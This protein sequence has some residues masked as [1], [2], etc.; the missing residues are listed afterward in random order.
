M[1]PTNEAQVKAINDADAC[2]NNV[3]LPNYSDLMKQVMAQNE[4]LAKSVVLVEVKNVYGNETIYPAN[5]A[6]RIF[7]AIAGKKTLNTSDMIRIRELGFTVEQAMN[8]ID[9]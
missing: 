6:G 7:A 5:N 2:L 4:A 8:K 3:D 1:K 9:L